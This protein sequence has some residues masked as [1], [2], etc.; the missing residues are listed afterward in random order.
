[1][2]DPKERLQDILQAIEAID[3]YRACER[4]EFDRHLYQLRSQ[5][6][7]LP[8]SLRFPPLREGNRRVLVPPACRGNL[9]E[10]VINCCFL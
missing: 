2:R 9:K 5:S 10:G 3:R 6:S 8:P 1:M 7:Q 4:G